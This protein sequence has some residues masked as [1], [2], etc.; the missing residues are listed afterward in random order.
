[1]KPV[2]VAVEMVFGKIFVVLYAVVITDFASFCP[3]P[4]FDF[5]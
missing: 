4:R 1:M 5:D 3:S 2:A